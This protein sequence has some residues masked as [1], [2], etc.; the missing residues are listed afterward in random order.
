VIR[1]VI[2]WLVALVCA[3][4]LEVVFTPSLAVAGFIGFT[5]GAIAVLVGFWWARRAG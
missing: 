3:L 5:F 2:S 4:A 1:V